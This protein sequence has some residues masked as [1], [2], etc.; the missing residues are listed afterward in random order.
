MVWEN[1]EHDQPNGNNMTDLVLD[2][3]SPEDEPGEVESSNRRAAEPAK[4]VF[5]VRTRDAFFDRIVTQLRTSLP[6]ELRR[7]QARPMFLL[8]KIAFDNERVHYEVAIDNAR[9]TLEIAL[10]FE[11]GPASTLRYLALFDKQ[12]VELKHLLG[13][14]VDLERWTQSWGRLYELRPLTTLDRGVANEVAERLDLYIRTLQPMLDAAA[15]PPER[16][17]GVTPSRRS[18]S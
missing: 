7:F 12:I 13:H 3:D 14:E 2:P 10:H 5:S 15:I 16:S 18:R 17:A 6:A 4:L 9:R 11:D 8:M 1:E